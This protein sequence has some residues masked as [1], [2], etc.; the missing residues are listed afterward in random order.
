MFVTPPLTT[1]RREMIHWAWLWTL[2]AI[3]IYL[4]YR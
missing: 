1:R 2:T 3:V 4:L